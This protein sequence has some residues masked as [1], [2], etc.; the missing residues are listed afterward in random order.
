MDRWPSAKGQR[1][2][3]TMTNKLPITYNLSGLG[4]EFSSP[5]LILNL[6]T[7]TERYI[8]PALAA[9]AN[10]LAFTRRVSREFDSLFTQPPQGEGPAI[11]L[12]DDEDTQGNHKIGDT[13]FI[14][15]PPRFVGHSG[16]AYDPE[17]IE[18]AA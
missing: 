2:T 7:F 18:R 16:L 14:R 15:R 3:S 5:G 11:Y 13:L 6:E 8:Q 9:L 10:H 12:E 17:V 1:F 4:F